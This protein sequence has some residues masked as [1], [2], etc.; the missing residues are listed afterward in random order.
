MVI[1]SL[2]GAGNEGSKAA[3]PP[4]SV[5]LNPSNCKINFVLFLAPIF[6]RKIIRCLY[7]IT[8]KKENTLAKR[9]KRVKVMD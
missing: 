2:A 9:E 7:L 5:F 4:T 1:L 6:P 8:I 3:Q